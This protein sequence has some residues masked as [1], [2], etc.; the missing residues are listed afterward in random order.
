MFQLTED[1]V[2]LK[3]HM[4]SCFLVLLGACTQTFTDLLSVRDIDDL[5]CSKETQ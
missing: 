1:N 5:S 4:M 3:L 2:P